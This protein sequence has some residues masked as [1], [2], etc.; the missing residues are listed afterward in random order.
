MEVY[1]PVC[2]PQNIIWTEAD[3][4]EETNLITKNKTYVSTLVPLVL[5][6]LLEFYLC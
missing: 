4:N 3:G 2:Q 5:N 6:G 1:G